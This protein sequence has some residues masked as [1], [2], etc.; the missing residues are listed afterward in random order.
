[1]YDGS[2]EEAKLELV[3]RLLVDAS[4]SIRLCWILYRLV[5]W[6]LILLDLRVSQLSSSSI[7][8]HA[9]GVVI[10]VEC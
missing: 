7:E 10:S 5:S 6:S 1:M 3:R 9:T 4:A 8:V 2:R